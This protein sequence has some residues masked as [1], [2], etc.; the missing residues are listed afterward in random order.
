MLLSIGVS[1]QNYIGET[2]TTIKN[3]YETK[4]MYPEYGVSD[5]G[6]S[7]IKI[8]DTDSKTTKLYYMDKGVCYLYVIGADYSQYGTYSKTLNDIGYKQSDGTYT[9]YDKSGVYTSWINT[10]SD[11]YF[12]ILTLIKTDN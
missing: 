2:K 9:I 7:F 4:G 11:E 5:D 3:A 10:D 8:K 6:T 12:M 1:A